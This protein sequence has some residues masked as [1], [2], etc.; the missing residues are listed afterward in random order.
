MNLSERGF[1]F[2]VRVVVVLAM[3]FLIVRLV[4]VIV[5]GLSAP[6]CY[7]STMG[8]PDQV[9]QI[10]GTP[11]ACTN[12]LHGYRCLKMEECHP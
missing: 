4:E 10:D 9:V 6:R 2:V 7:R 3:A 8:N 11:F 12:G 5:Q 1:D